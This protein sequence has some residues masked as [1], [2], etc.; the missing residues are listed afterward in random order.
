MWKNNITPFYVH[1]LLVKANRVPEVENNRSDN[2]PTTVQENKSTNEKRKERDKLVGSNSS[3]TYKT[4][5]SKKESKPK[6]RR[7]V[8]QLTPEQSI[9]LHQNIAEYN[10]LVRMHYL[11]QDKMCTRT[12]GLTDKQRSCLIQH[13][14]QYDGLVNTEGKRNFDI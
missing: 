8:R 6:T 1:S 9:I 5:P 7:I 11:K 10:D 13:I 2:Q 3:F 14:Q 12:A 4:S